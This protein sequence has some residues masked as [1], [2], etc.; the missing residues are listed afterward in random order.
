MLE[1]RGHVGVLLADVDEHLEALRLAIDGAAKNHLDGQNRS[2][3]HSLEDTSN[4]LF[5][6]AAIDPR[7]DDAVGG[8][9]R[10]GRVGRH[11]ELEALE[12]R[13]KAED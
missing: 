2:P 6:A 7:K 12:S 5:G 3:V 1:H 4:I 10:N 8:S 13:K 9:R 11:G